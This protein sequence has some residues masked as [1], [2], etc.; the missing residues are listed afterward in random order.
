[1]NAIPNKHFAIPPYKAVRYSND[2]SGIENAQKLNVLTFTD[3][4][5]AKFTSYE[6]AVKIAQEWNS[7][8]I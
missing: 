5:G 4:P 1:M 8:A 7:L 6:N 3:K 2:F